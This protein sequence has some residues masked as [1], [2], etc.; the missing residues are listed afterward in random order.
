MLFLLIFSFALLLANI[1]A[2]N[3]KRYLY[4]FIPCMLFLPE[5]YGFD[6]SNSLPIISIY[7]I[8]FIVF[9]IYSFVNRRRDFHIK[10]LS[11]K[12]IPLP[13]YFIAC[14][15]IFRLIPNIF[16]C[17]S[18]EYAIKTIFLV[19]CQQMLLV[20]AVYLL[21][22][23][24][25]EI[26]KT[27]KSTVW[28]GATLFAVGIFESFT[29]IRPFD[30]LY[31]VQRTMLNDHYIRLGLLRSTTTMG[32]PGLYGNMCVLILVLILYLYNI[33]H[34]KKYLWI[35]PLNILAIIHSGSRSDN[36]Y[37]ILILGLYII[38][39]CLTKERLVKLIKHLSFGTIILMVIISTLSLY[40]P[41]YKY[42]YEGNAK[43]ILNEFGAHYDLNEN[44]PDGIAGYGVNA[45]GKKA[46]GSNS[47]F[48]QFSG[49]KY[50]L[51]HKPFIGLGSGADERNVLHY[52]WNN[53]WYICHWYDVG[54]VQII[55]EE[56]LLGLLS[57]LALFIA[58]ILMIL[59]I[60]N[61][62]MNYSKLL[63]LYFITYLVT[64]LSTANMYSFLS[65]LLI[66]CICKYKAE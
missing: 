28:T 2:F 26:L 27:I 62:D 45:G 51:E 19:I 8:M 33:T 13:Y 15:F 5:Y 53:T 61:I 35:I 14:Y 9:Y 54:I 39:F 34:E 40:S 6:I 18:N 57:H 31:T 21:A 25:E 20:F 56:G 36:I 48:V 38:L 52:Y 3:S 7:R 17:T 30:A 42:Y 60:R 16:Y 12:A 44:A 50:T 63:I 47:R 24:S 46:G 43:A 4:L 10:A 23:T 1:Y 65:F 66:L 49:I 58:I 55:C 59:K 41:V 29:S 64:T 32:L 37:L 22:P 11:F